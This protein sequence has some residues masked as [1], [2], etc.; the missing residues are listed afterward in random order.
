MRKQKQKQ[1]RVYDLP[2]QS[3]VRKLKRTV[4]KQND[5]QRAIQAEVGRVRDE[6]KRGFEAA[7]SGR[8]LSDWGVGHAH[9]NDEV[10]QALATMRSRS[11]EKAKNS[12]YVKNYFQLL[13]TNGVGPAGFT[14]KSRAFTQQGINQT[15][16][17]AINDIVES[18]WRKFCAKGV[19]EVSGKHSMQ[20]LLCLL[21]SSVARDGDALV[22]IHAVPKTKKN[23]Y[24]ISLQ[25]L[26]VDRLDTG[27]NSQI[28]GQNRIVMGVELDD[29]NKPVAYH[30]TPYTSSQLDSKAKAERI[31]ADEILHLYKAEYPEQIR[32]V[33]WLHSVMV[34]LHNLHAFEAYT[35]ISA[36]VGAANM[37]FLTRTDATGGVETMADGVDEFGDFYIDA[38]PGMFQALP[39]GMDVKVFNPA[40]PTSAYG[41]FTKS[42]KRSIANGLAVPFYLLFSDLV[43]VNYSSSRQE[44]QSCNDMFYTMHAWLINSFLIPVYEAW[45]KAAFMNSALTDHTG[46]AIPDTLIDN[47]LTNF[48]FK[49]R[50]FPQVDPKGDLEALILGKKNGVYSAQRI[51]EMM[52]EDYFETVQQLAAEREEA[53]RLDIYVEDANDPQLNAEMADKKEAREV[54]AQ[55][56]AQ[57]YENASKQATEADT[58]AKTQDEERK[59]Q[60]E[61]LSRQFEAVQATMREVL[62]RSGSEKPVQLM[63]AEELGAAL[64]AMAPVVEQ[65]EPD[66]AP[67]QTAEE[68]GQ[69]L[70]ELTADMVE[71]PAAEPVAEAAPEPTPETPQEPTDEPEAIEPTPATTEDLEQAVQELE[72]VV[73]EFEADMPAKQEQEGSNDEQQ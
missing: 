15:P 32:G 68:L 1:T 11:R 46:K 51:A 21:L 39:A 57:A 26:S 20:G 45:I 30:L 54:Q 66:P 61:A 44:K 40:Y 4:V 38:E 34:P 8:L 70:A 72:A 27:R 43:D 28:Q 64:A 63:T 33:P 19:C 3:P 59:A 49:G 37:G 2:K 42:N 53:V 67:E 65:V 17:V 23:P 22:R 60:F 7:N 24:G 48:T 55:A 29:F 25:V 5:E 41:D 62:E 71:A 58:Q 52:G 56:M 13:E 69:V 31:H 14:F 12:P 73:A 35:L 9:I 36:R 10:L 50:S 47:L 16:L 18:H 6:M